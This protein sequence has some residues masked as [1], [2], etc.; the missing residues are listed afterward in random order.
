[1]RSCHS[2]SLVNL[3]EQILRAGL[4]NSAQVTRNNGQPKLSLN[5][6]TAVELEH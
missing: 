2:L 1:M 3:L 5:E 4:E 6:G